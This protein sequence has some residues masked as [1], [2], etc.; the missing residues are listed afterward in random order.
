MQTRRWSLVALVLSAC[1]P[2]ETPTTSPTSSPLLATMQWSQD[3]YVAT[4]EGVAIVDHEALSVSAGNVLDPECGIKASFSLTSPPPGT[5]E[6]WE[7]LPNDALSVRANAPMTSTTRLSGAFLSWSSEQ[8]SVSEACAAR[9]A[10]RPPLEITV[11]LTWDVLESVEY[12]LPEGGRPI[13]NPMVLGQSARVEL[14]Y[15][16]RGRSGVVLN[17]ALN[18]GDVQDFFIPSPKEGPINVQATSDRISFLGPK[19]PNKYA[20]STAVG[21][22]LRLFVPPPE[23]IEQ[24]ALSWTLLDGDHREDSAQVGETLLASVEAITGAEGLLYDVPSSFGATIQSLTPSVCQ[25]SASR[26]DGVEVSDRV[27]IQASGTCEVEVT[28]GVAKVA[29]TFD[30]P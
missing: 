13:G 3:Q 14:F 28:L 22:S 11:E 25:T 15:K 6:T 26:G 12:E 10:A 24:V 29:K 27:V 9:L 30:V 21:E 1:T 17:G 18:R 16:M 19:T 2:Q 5:Q 20:L 23:E 4:I 7:A 8:G